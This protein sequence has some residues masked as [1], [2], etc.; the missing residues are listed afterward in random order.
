[1]H[2]AMYSSII[3]NPNLSIVAATHTHQRYIY[4]KCSAHEIVTSNLLD[5][6]FL[7]F[8]NIFYALYFI[9]INILKTINN[10]VDI[11]NA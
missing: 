10:N 7:F 1:M 11:T 2:S 9:T 5:S 4:K 8:N 3:A 6:V